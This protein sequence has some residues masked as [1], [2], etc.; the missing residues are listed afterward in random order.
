MSL[1]SMQ[2]YEIYSN[3]MLYPSFFS[4]VFLRNKLS[5]QYHAFLVLVHCHKVYVCDFL[6]IME[7]GVRS[8]VAETK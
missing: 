8:L 5:T 7:F 4:V 2:I 6:S 3:H 1:N